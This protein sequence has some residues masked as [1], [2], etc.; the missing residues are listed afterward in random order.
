[1]I[2][3]V[4]LNSNKNN[5]NSSVLLNN[6]STHTASA[7]EPA[8]NNSNPAKGKQTMEQRKMEAKETLQ[9]NRHRKLS[10]PSSFEEHQERRKS[11]S[12][13]SFQMSP[14]SSS[15]RVEEL[16]STSASNSNCFQIDY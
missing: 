6:P 15:P 16:S 11:F 7:G 13:P 8:G 5:T 2:V 1:M 3:R 4:G 12:Y 10:S 14:S 9:K